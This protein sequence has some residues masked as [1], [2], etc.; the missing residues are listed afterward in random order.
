MNL[1]NVKPSQIKQSN[2]LSER[3]KA[4][5]QNSVSIMPNGDPDGGAHSQ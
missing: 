1:L 2:L 3:E 4:R 5:K